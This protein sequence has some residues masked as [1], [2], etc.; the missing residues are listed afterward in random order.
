MTK[1]SL[2]AQKLHNNLLS[3][4]S[5]YQERQINGDILKSNNTKSSTG[6]KGKEMDS[7]KPKYYSANADKDVRAE[8]FLPPGLNSPK[9]GNKG[10]VGVVTPLLYQHLDTEQLN[11]VN[12]GQP[13]NLT[14]TSKQVIKHPESSVHGQKVDMIHPTENTTGW[15]LSDRLK[16]NHQAELEEILKNCTEPSSTSILKPCS[17]VSS[18][19]SRSVIKMQVKPVET[20]LAQS[21]PV[22]NPQRFKLAGTAVKYPLSDKN[23]KNDQ[24]V[25][26]SPT[27]SQKHQPENH[28]AKSTESESSSKNGVMRVAETRIHP[29]Y[30]QRNSPL[31][32]PRVNHSSQLPFQNSVDR[33]DQQLHENR[34]QIDISSPVIGQRRN[35]HSVVAPSKSMTEAHA[36]S[37]STQSKTLPRIHHQ[38]SLNNCHLQV[39]N[40]AAVHQQAAATEDSTVH[41]QVTRASPA[42]TSLKHSD[43]S[44]TPGGYSS[45]PRGHHI[46][47]A[48][49]Q[50]AD[51]YH[52]C[53][54]QHV[55]QHEHES[56]ISQAAL[57]LSSKLSEAEIFL[58][59]LM[60]PCYGPH[61]PLKPFDDAA[62]NFFNHSQAFAKL[63]STSSSLMDNN[64]AFPAFC[65]P[66][67]AFNQENDM[68]FSP[69]SSFKSFSQS[70][71]YKYHSNEA[72]ATYQSDSSSEKQSHAVCG[73]SQSFSKVHNP[74]VTVPNPLPVSTGM[75]PP[76][77]LPHMLPQRGMTESAHGHLTSHIKSSHCIVG[78][79]ESPTRIQDK[80]QKFRIE[81]SVIKGRLLNIIIA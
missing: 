58:H 70:S 48:Y 29:D 77:T 66:L 35:C 46:H 39:F 30:Q 60:K 37:F 67:Q 6:A 33:V 41:E 22:L 16:Y 59:D 8:S 13:Q 49:H 68:K 50:P 11:Q 36:D 10:R 75:L 72:T 65:S 44:G 12:P 9:P 80:S 57:P 40:N 64:M 74:L 47:Q 4:S 15:N 26:T 71:F 7:S 23:E 5:M 81:I 43:G 2:I 14:L 25:T 55:G 76:L 34:K 52:V 28:N 21:L 78:A 51:H 31:V 1:D 79:Q 62:V 56:F 61:L 20:H 69:N 3:H 42:A 63:S 38:N 54:N 24:Q 17:L 53:H 73:N 32:R 18:P 27:V 45:L 19:T